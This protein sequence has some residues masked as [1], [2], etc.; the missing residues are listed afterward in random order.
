M[1]RTGTS[2][3]IEGL[4]SGD[5]AAWSD[6]PVGRPAA[7]ADDVMDAY[8]ARRFA[9]AA[10]YSRPGREAAPPALFLSGSW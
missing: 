2:G 8:L 3:Q 4:L 10:D 1:T 5:I 9:A 7:R 6:T